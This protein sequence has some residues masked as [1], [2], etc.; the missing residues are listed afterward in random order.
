MNAKRSLLVTHVIALIAL[1]AIS[2]MG[3]VRDKVTLKPFSTLLSQF[4]GWKDLAGEVTAVAEREGA[5]TIVLAGRDLTAEMLYY[6]RGSGLNIRTLAADQMRPENHF[7]MT[8]P[9]KDS[10]PMPAIIAIIGKGTPEMLA[11]YGART[12]GEVPTRIF[13]ARRIGIVSFHLVAAGR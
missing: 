5:K 13:A 7:E 4:D 3:I 12:V 1:I 8:R 10:D 11:P 6:L 2:A 9:Y